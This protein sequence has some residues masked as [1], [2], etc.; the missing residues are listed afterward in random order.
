LIRLLIVDDSAVMRRAIRDMVIAEPRIEVV[1]TARNGREAIEMNRALKP[2]VVTMDVEMPELDGLASLTAI[3]RD[4]PTKVIMLSS[5]TVKG[6]KAIAQAFSLG[7]AD[8]LAK[9]VTD[10]GKQSIE[11]L[12]S[13]LV[14]RVLALAP[15]DSAGRA[16][17]R[18]AAKLPP[19]D[20]VVL[21]ALP[22]ELIV[23]GSSTGGPAL[24]EKILRSLPV[25][26]S[27]PVVVAQHMPA[28]FTQSMAERLNDLC[29]VSVQ[30]VTARTALLPGGAY[31]A[32]G[33]KHLHIRRVPGARA[34]FEG[35]MS[36]EPKSAIFKPSV[37]VLL[38]SAAVA[39][40][41]R[42]LAAVLTGIGQDGML[43]ARDISLQGGHVWA[44]DQ[45]SCSVYGMPRAV[46]E[47]G[48]A[49][50]ILTPAEM[51]MALAKVAV[52]PQRTAA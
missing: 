46:A 32:Q 31:V 49:N 26:F 21:P 33:G 41:K 17:D 24:V 15:V 2:D 10:G 6:S 23:I 20:Q 5:L 22:P 1:G 37:D 18:L 4:R 44:Q 7:A 30:H 39:A 45:A 35:M 38:S 25:G 34:A 13:L 29:N 52:I 8:A 28:M 14:E 51:I 36:D 11:H 16:T 43:G 42:T 47:G 3:M 12:R 27:I 9:D 48:Y 50:A 19:K 40:G